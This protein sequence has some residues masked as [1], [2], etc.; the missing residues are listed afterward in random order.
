MR[1][2]SCVCCSGPVA[3]CRSLCVGRCVLF[4]VWLSLFLVCVVCRLTWRGCCSLLGM[5][6]SLVRG[7]WRCVVLFVVG[8]IGS[9]LCVVRSVM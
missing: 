6:L 4:V 3:M 9:A 2:L 8:S 7:V 1:C 5:L